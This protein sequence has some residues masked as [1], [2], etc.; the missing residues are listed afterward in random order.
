MVRS[1]GIANR[2]NHLI[3]VYHCDMY[4]IDRDKIIMIHY[5]TPLL[6]TGTTATTI[7]SLT[8]GPSAFKEPPHK[9]VVGEHH[10]EQALHITAVHLHSSRA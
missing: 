4:I 6:G 3:T 2:I 7:G 9:L 10:L 5:H 1:T 8:D